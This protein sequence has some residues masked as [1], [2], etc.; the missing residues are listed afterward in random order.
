MSTATGR[1]VDVVES[2]CLESL[3]TGLV[4]ALGDE[5]ARERLLECLLILKRG[6]E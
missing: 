4:K 5:V 6:N 3:S 1:A 2:A